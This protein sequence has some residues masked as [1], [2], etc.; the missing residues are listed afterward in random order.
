[1]STA[2]TTGE[3]KMLKLDAFAHANRFDRLYPRLG[4]EVR[5]RKENGQ[6]YHRPTIGFVHPS[7]DFVADSYAE[8]LGGM[9][10]VDAVLMH[11]VNDSGEVFKDVLAINDL[12]SVL[13]EV[14]K[15]AA[16]KHGDNAAQYCEREWPN[17]ESADEYWK[18]ADG[19]T[20][21]LFLVDYLVF[22]SDHLDA[23]CVAAA[24]RSDRA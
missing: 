18:C 21:V 23:E 1:M 20:R 17:A 13:R 5:F 24:Y 6:R 14:Q 15:N 3:Q 4:I 16:I 9:A 8:D 22:E 11:A 10:S 7:G 19:P 12:N 2:R